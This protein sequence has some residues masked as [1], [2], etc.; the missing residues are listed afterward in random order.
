MFKILFLSDEK[1]KQNTFQ[2]CAIKAI[3][4]NNNLYLHQL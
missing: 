4:K 2:E 1:W 3:K